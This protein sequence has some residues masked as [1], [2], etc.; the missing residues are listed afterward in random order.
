LRTATNIM[1]VVFSLH[2]GAAKIVA[3]GDSN[4]RPILGDNATERIDDYLSLLNQGYS[5][6]EIFQ[7]LGNANLL[8]KNYESASFWYEKLLQ[9]ATSAAQRSRYQERFAYATQKSKGQLRNVDKDWTEE[10]L[11]DYKAIGKSHFLL[12]ASFLSHAGATSNPSK[13]LGGAEEYTPKLTVTGNG[14]IAFFSKAVL[15]KPETGIFSKKEVFHEIYR[16]E[17]IN[18]KWRNITKLNVCPKYASAKHPTVSADG[19]RL[20]FASNMPGSYGK[21][22]IYVAEIGRNGSVGRA[23]N[24]G[25]KVNTKKNDLYPSVVNGSTLVFASDGRK[26]QGGLDLFAVTVKGNQL[27]QSKNLGNSINSSHDDFALTFSPTKGMGFVVS[28]RGDQ[29]TVGQYSITPQKERSLAT[30][31]KDDEK[32]WNALNDDSKIEYSSTL[33]EDN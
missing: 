33:F 18:G 17:N 13:K 28:N 5:E 7:D 19:T 31:E 9:N 21:Y 4:T 27:G 3:Q 10:I 29:R 1:V 24:L 32:L 8:S 15:G 25:S 14:K 6:V 22:D 12:D 16:A 2:V 30:F 20:F 23:K 11:Q 26:G